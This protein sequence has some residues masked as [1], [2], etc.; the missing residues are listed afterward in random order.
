[1]TVVAPNPDVVKKAQIFRHGLMEMW[2]EDVGE[3]G[4]CEVQ[5]LIRPISPVF[6][7][8]KQDLLSVV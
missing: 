7:L 3:D 2:G 8:I 4:Q 5:T 1:M 6:Y